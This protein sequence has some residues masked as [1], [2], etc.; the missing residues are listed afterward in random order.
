M[1]DRRGARPGSRQRHRPSRSQAGQCL[2]RPAPGA[3]S[4]PLSSCSTSGWPGGGVP[5]AAGESAPTAALLTGEGAILGTLRTWHRSNSRDGGGR[6]GRH[7]CVWRRALRDAHRPAGVRGAG[8][9]SLIAAILTRDPPPVSTRFRACRRSSTRVAGVSRRTRRALAVDADV[10]CNCAGSPSI[11]SVAAAATAAPPAARRGRLWWRTAA[12]A[13]L[14]AIAAALALIARRTDAP[15]AVV[16]FEVPPPPGTS[17]LSAGF[18]VSYHGGGRL[19]RRL[20]HHPPAIGA[21]G[22]RRLWLR[23]TDAAEPQPLART[24]GG[25]LP[26]WS[27]DDRSI[28]FFA[29]GKLMRLDLP[30]GTRRV[31][32]DAPLGF[33]GTW[34]RD[35]VIVFAPAA[36]AP[37]HRVSAAGGQVVAVTAS[38]RPAGSVAPVPRLPARRAP[39]LSWRAAR[40]PNR[41]R[42]SSGRST[43]PR[44]KP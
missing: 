26:F 19:P 31:L 22:V 39:H 35:G 21:D 9:A 14:L 3:S 4:P 18:G 44:P 33:G 32:C 24:E 37:L 10:C 16:H 40:S 2:A 30:D 8:Q 20:A 11:R 7:L 6:P 15:G 43:R 12:L 29:D 36:D 23:R 5:L 28:A 27:P 42:C 38:M 41:A 25:F 34:S 13:L 17:F 1:P